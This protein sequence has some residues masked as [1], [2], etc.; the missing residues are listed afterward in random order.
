[1]A[2]RIAGFDEILTPAGRHDGQGLLQQSNDMRKITSW[3]AIIAVP[4]MVVGIYGMN[5]DFM[6][7]LRWRLGYPLVITVILI[8]PACSSTALSNA[9][10]GCDHH[11]LPRIHHHM[12]EPAVHVFAKP[13]FWLVLLLLGWLVLITCRSHSARALPRP[14]D[15]TG[16]EPGTR[17]RWQCPPMRTLGRRA[18]LRGVGG[19]TVQAPR[20]RRLRAGMVRSSLWWPTAS[21]TMSTT[22]GSS[23]R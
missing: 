9:T 14:A 12:P 17:G 22:W 4:N 3:A 19:G 6:P 13:M 21:W 1:V 23:A 7:E 8:W 20:A 10:T 11:V 2:E 5:F 18:R 15:P 16:L